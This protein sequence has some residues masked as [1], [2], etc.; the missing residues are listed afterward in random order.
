MFYFIGTSTKDQPINIVRRHCSH[1]RKVPDIYTSEQ[2]K[3]VRIVF[4][5]DDSTNF[6]SDESGVVIGYATFKTET[7]SQ[8][9][10]LSLFKPIPT[11]PSTGSKILANFFSVVIIG[12]MGT[13]VF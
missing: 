7:R 10:C 1:I 8:A 12:T 2:L 11:T 3:S 5:S 13:L 4:E 9:E 6:I